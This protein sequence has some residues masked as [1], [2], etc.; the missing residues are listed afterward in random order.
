MSALWEREAL[1][2]C[3]KRTRT[4]QDSKVSSKTNAPFAHHRTGAPPR[5]RR[6]RK[7]A[8]SRDQQR[9]AHT[10]ASCRRGAATAHGET[11]STPPH[12]KQPGLF[13]LRCSRQK[14]PS[15]VSEQKGT[16]LVTPNQHLSMQNICFRRSV[17][18]LLLWG[19]RILAKEN[20]SLE[21]P[22]IRNRYP[23]SPCPSSVCLPY[24][25]VS[26]LFDV[27]VVWTNFGQRGADR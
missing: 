8:R 20:Q 18:A 6:R 19:N 7:K 13:A 16:T 25:S 2:C 21:F 10:S 14:H 12:A 23:T 17:D 3:R 24:P 4:A 22:S 11:R 26:H 1:H 15:V 5:T 27:F 9:A